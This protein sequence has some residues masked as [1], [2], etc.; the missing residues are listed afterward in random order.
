[1]VAWI[2]I[3]WSAFP[4]TQPPSLT[5]VTAGFNRSFLRDS[6][7]FRS[8]LEV[9]GE[10]IGVDL[11]AP[12]GGGG[13]GGPAEGLTMDGGVS[14]VVVGELILCELVAFGVFGILGDLVSN[15]RHA[16]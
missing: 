9:K 7:V 3:S 14:L 8:E 13:G 5:K 10:F 16:M 11:G 12:T 15:L 2:R 1:M 6:I 4:S